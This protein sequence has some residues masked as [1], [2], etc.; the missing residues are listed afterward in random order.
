MKKLLFITLFQF[1]FG[2]VFAQT[3]F[4]TTWKTENPGGSANNQITI[5]TTGTGYNYSVAWEKADDATVSGTDGPFTGDATVTFP[6]VGT[7]RLSISGAFPRIFFNNTGDREKLLTVEQ[8]GSN[9]WQSMERAFAGCSNLTIP[10]QDVPNLTN[11]TDMSRMFLSATSFNQPIGNWDV[12]SVTNMSRMFERASSFDQPIGNWDVS[13]VTDMTVMF[14]RASAFNQDIGAWNVSN[15]TNMIAMFALDSAFNQDIS[16]WNVENVTDI[17]LMFAG[18]IAFN[19]D[20]G[21]WNV[22]N[23]AVMVNTFQGATAFNQNLGRWNI[24][25]VIFMSS[26]LDDSGVS[27]AN[28]DSTL[29][30]WA[31]LP[32]LQNNVPF[33]AGGLSYC[34]GEAA[35]DSLIN[36]YNW[37]ITDAGRLCPTALARVDSKAVGI[38]K[39]EERLTDI[40]IYP[41]PAKDQFITVFPQAL[42][43][44]THWVLTDPMG[45]EVAT[46]SL[47]EGTTSQVTPTH[48]L[49]PGAY[50]YR[51]MAGGS[52]VKTKRIIVAR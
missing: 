13:S 29:I 42:E 15:V 2:Y 8:W 4:I 21:S 3:P 52:V 11:V 7:Y 1:I 27:V 38:K 46:G 16:A 28:Y 50:F 37:T 35:R 48:A 45:K 22:S 20:I 23:V 30:G 43:A 5:P 39:Q 31:S 33:G 49:A 47:E 10:A 12:S 19:Q 26:M 36:L 34:N 41:N 14:F 9:P 18:A 40:T 32:S 17:S 44:P 24:E 51:L 25:K 6:Q